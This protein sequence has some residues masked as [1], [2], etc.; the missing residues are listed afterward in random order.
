MKI[1]QYALVLSFI[2]ICN[3]TLFAQVESS[4]WGE[5]RGIRVDGELMPIST[6]I[7]AVGP[8]WKQIAATAHWRT[9]NPTY[10]RD[11]D[12]SIINTGQLG[13]GLRGGASLNFHQTVK[14]A[15][16]NSCTLDIEVTAESDMHLEGVYL[17]VTVPAADFG[18][19]SGEL[20]DAQSAAKANFATTRP[21]NDKH[22]IAGSSAKGARFISTNRQVEITFD[23]PRD[24]TIQDDRG[25][26]EPSLT[27]LF[28]LSVGDLKSGQ[29]IHATCKI[30]VSGAVDKSLAT[31]QIDPSQRGSTFAGVGGNFCWGT[32]VPIVNF[33]LDNLRVKWARVA[34]LL[35]QWQPR[36]NDDPTT[37]PV[38][39]LGPEI[40]ECLRMASE[41]HRRNIPMIIS[42]WNAPDWALAS[43]NGGAGA[44]GANRG[45]RHVDK[46]DGLAKS[47]GDYLLMFKK[48]VGDEP[49]LFSFNESNLGINVLMSPTEHRDM[50]KLL[51]AHFASLGLRTKMLLGDAN[52]PRAVDYVKAALADPEAMKYVGAVS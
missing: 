1:L 10:K 49:Q 41:L 50:I 44:G 27:L 20:I 26:S 31:V 18:Q 28:P 8:G 37:R 42:V 19:G 39:E 4:G 17:F 23:Q 13:F 33:Y 12:K 5:L 25:Q 11:A 30:K 7:C 21:A 15:G 46:W 36:E 3:S 34:M 29:K 38:E 51:G 24:V 35:P 32:Q 16:A 14:D 40:R 47:I 48:V 43:R 2:L 9:R 52:E 6:K 22:Y 45:G